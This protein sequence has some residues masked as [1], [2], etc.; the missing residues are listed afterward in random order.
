MHVFRIR[1]GNAPAYLSTNF[2]PIAQ[3]HSY[4]TRGSTHDFRISR[5]LATSPKSFAFTAIKHWN[6]LSQSLK[7]IESLQCFKSGLKQHL[8]S[9]YWLISWLHAPATDIPSITVFIVIFFLL[10]PI[11]NKSFDFMGYPS[12]FMLLHVV[13][14]LNRKY[15]FP[16][17]FQHF[18]MS[19]R[20]D[21]Q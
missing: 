17:K 18:P 7:G 1:A 15:K 19:T 5:E 2:Q 6:G 21:L 10:D 20:A 9:E 16:T 12:V 8:L 13:T 3:G 4:N 14:A 11:G